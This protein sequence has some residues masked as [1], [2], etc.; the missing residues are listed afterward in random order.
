MIDMIDYLFEKYDEGKLSVDKM[1]LLVEKFTL[2]SKDDRSNLA[3]SM[4]KGA[5]GGAIAGAV[6]TKLGRMISKDQYYKKGKQLYI[7]FKKKKKKLENGQKLTEEE[8][9]KLKEL[10]T[11]PEYKDL[12]NYYKDSRKKANSIIKTS[13][14][15]SAAASGDMAIAS[16]NSY[17]A[18][19]NK[20]KYD[21]ETEAIKKEV[22]RRG[23][24]K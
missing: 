13:A 7:E 11:N 6:G 24:R 22:D 5:A 8:Q 14:I 20:G 18:G 4:V 9:K 15:I 10:K 2:K 16:K 17:D 12:I 1:L 23:L 19:Y 21:G 3:K